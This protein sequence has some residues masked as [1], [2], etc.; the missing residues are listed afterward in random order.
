VRQGLNGDEK[1][2]VQGAGLISDGERVEV[3]R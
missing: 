2:V 3:I 1:I